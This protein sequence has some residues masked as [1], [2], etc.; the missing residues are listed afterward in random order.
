MLI[1]Y[2]I[3]GPADVTIKQT[4]KSL[5]EAD[6][7]AY[8]QRRQRKGGNS[9]HHRR[10]DLQMNTSR[11]ARNPTLC[12]PLMT[13]SGHNHKYSRTTVGCLVL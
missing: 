4:D 6:A 2:E 11:I 3:D 8:L 5:S 9:Q 10:R 13:T 12:P 7:L 1:V